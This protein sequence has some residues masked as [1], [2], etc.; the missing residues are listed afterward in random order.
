[1]VKKN[2]FPQ[3]WQIEQINKNKKSAESAKSVR[4]KIVLSIRCLYH[5]KK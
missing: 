5:I 3:I 4:E 2:N 1:V